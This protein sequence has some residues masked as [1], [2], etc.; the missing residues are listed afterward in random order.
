VAEEK[1]EGQLRPAIAFAERVDGVEVSE[2][3]GGGGNE[4]LRVRTSGEGCTPQ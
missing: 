4:G 1:E 3:A 2:E